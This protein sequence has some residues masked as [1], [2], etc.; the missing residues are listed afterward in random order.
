M[1][2]RLKLWTTQW[3]D[4]KASMPVVISHAYDELGKCHLV[5]NFVLKPEPDGLSVRVCYEELTS[6]PALAVRL[7]ASKIKKAHEAALESLAKTLLLAPKASAQSEQEETV[8]MELPQLLTASSMLDWDMCEMTVVKP[9]VAQR[10]PVSNSE[11]NSSLKRIELYKSQMR[12]LKRQEQKHAAGSTVLALNA[13][14]DQWERGAF[15]LLF[16]SYVR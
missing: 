11:L 12:R 3:V 14:L 4:E 15:V 16:F 8:E 9:V 7:G 5:S 6:S 2:L 10:K 13:E 1:V